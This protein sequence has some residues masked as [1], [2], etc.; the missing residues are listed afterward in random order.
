MNHIFGPAQTHGPVAE[1][2]HGARHYDGWQNVTT[3]GMFGAHGLR[4]KPFGVR[5]FFHY[6]RS[7]RRRLPALA[8]DAH[9]VGDDPPGLS[10]SCCRV[11]VEAHLG[12]VQHNSLAR[13]IGK[14]VLSRQDNACA[15]AGQPE[16]NARIGQGKLVQTKVVAAG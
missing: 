10:L 3:F 16:V 8:A 1:G 12:Q 15:F 4:R 11:I 7:T 9:G 13:C 6:R 14:Q 2:V 5:D